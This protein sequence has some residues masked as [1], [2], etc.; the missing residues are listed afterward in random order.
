MGCKKSHKK[1][2]KLNCFRQVDNQKNIKFFLPVGIFLLADTPLA[3]NERKRKC[4]PA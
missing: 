1:S 3:R 4:T 2:L